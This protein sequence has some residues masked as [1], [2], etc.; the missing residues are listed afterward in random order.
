MRSGPARMQ[1]GISLPETLIG[2]S[3]GLMIVSCAMAL[4]LRQM[5]VRSRIS[6]DFQIRHELATLIEAMQRDVARTG[7]RELAEQGAW[8]LDGQ[9]PIP[10]AYGQ[11]L[12]LQDQQVLA[13]GDP[14]N[15]L[16]Y[17]YARHNNRRPWEVPQVP[18]DNIVTVNERFGFRLKEG[19]LD[20][21]LGG[22]WQP[23]S[24]PD[25]YKVKSLAVHLQAQPLGTVPDCV[26]PCGA[27]APALYSLIAHFDV[28][29]QAAKDAS[30]TYHHAGASMLRNVS[31]Q[32][33]ADCAA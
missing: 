12:V 27:C 28:Q 15:T 24:D 21:L 29:A 7:F 18:E 5:Q 32:A 11:V 9:V 3:L 23:L 4:A 6:L 22:A 8:L 31:V 16:R 19:R 30:M 25:L 1:A 14:G 17:N 13:I 20:F 26:D 10:N 2:L 33:P